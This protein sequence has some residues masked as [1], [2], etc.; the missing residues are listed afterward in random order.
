MLHIS[1]PKSERSL[2]LASSAASEPVLLRSQKGDNVPRSHYRM[3]KA[4]P[5]RASFG[6]D[7][8]R[9]IIASVIHDIGPSEMILSCNGVQ[10]YRFQDIFTRNLKG[11]PNGRVG[12]AMFLGFSIYVNAA[13]AVK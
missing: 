4:M 6:R 12:I 9:S 1:R 2:I 10:L 13:S 11:L 7:R 3:C 5:L 8:N